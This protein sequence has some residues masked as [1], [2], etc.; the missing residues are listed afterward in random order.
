MIG[1]IKPI[2]AKDI[3]KFSCSL[4][5]DV[6]DWAENIRNKEDGTTLD[7]V[8]HAGLLMLGENLK[9]EENIKSLNDNDNAG[10]RN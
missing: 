7:M 4:P 5:K 3:I 9:L 1:K 2:K 8:I 10:V 6:Y